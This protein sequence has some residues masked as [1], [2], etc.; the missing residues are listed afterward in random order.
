[1]S[2]PEWE[3]CIICRDP[4][5]YTGAPGVKLR[6]Y[7]K[8]TSQGRQ[9]VG[10]QVWVRNSGGPEIESVECLQAFQHLCQAL[11]SDGWEEVDAG[12]LF[13]MDPDIHP[14]FPCKFRRRIR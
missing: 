6:Y 3:T 2:Q 10:P 8:V 12:D 14:A 5:D 1:M 7:A 13:E 9:Y 4:R 11:K